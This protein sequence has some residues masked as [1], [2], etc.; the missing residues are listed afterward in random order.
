VRLRSNEPVPTWEWRRNSHLSV[1]SFYNLYHSLA[2]ISA[3]LTQGADSNL[4]AR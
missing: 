4:A 3:L 2:S 1:N